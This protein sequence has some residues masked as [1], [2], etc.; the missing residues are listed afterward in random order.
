MCE[1][2][3]LN[4][5]YTTSTRTAKFVCVPKVARTR[6]KVISAHTFHTSRVTCSQKATHTKKQKLHYDFS[7]LN[8]V[9]SHKT[10]EHRTTPPAAEQAK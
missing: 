5:I 7:K 8:Y 9:P 10:R 6:I 1:I 2:M 3:I 4:L